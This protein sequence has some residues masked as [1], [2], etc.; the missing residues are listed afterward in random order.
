MVGRTEAGLRRRCYLAVASMLLALGQLSPWLSDT[1]AWIG[2][3]APRGRQ[4]SSVV[5]AGPG[6]RP[7]RSAMQAESENDERMVRV[8]WAA[9]TKSFRVG[10]EEGETVADLKDAIGRTARVPPADQDLYFKGK[11]LERDDTVLLQNFKPVLE[12]PRLGETYP[13]IWMVD[14]REKAP[15]RTRKEI[16]EP[17]I[18]SDDDETYLIFADGFPIFLRVIFALVTAVFLYLVYDKEVLGNEPSWPPGQTLTVEQ[19]NA[20]R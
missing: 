8:Y 16:F 19:S 2:S 9:G 13:D 1:T 17:V 7:P 15:R 3:S 5:S 12:A 20:Q 4:P 18:S 6:I 10:W 11:L 14:T